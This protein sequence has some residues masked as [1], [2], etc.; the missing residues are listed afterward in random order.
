MLHSALSM[1]EY[2]IQA[3]DGDIGYAVNFYFDDR[4][5]FVRFVVCDGT[6]AFGRK[7]LIPPRAFDGKPDNCARVVKLCA[8]KGTIKNS[9]PVNTDKPVSR[10]QQ[11]ILD[12][13]YNW[14]LQPP[15]SEQALFGEPFLEANV[16]SAREILGY[17]LNDRDGHTST[18]RDFIIDDD[19]WAVD[20]LVLET[21]IWLPG[22]KYLLDPHWVEQIDWARRAMRCQV[23][24]DKI[25]NSPDYDPTAVI[26]PREE[27]IVQEHFGP[28]QYS[29]QKALEEIIR[30][31][32]QE[33]Y[34]QRGAKP[35]NDWA[36]WFEA[37]RQVKDELNRL[38]R[39]KAQE[40]CARRGCQP[41][42]ELN[43]WFEAERIVQK[44]IRKRKMQ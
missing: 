1:K 34:A 33:L 32:A 4:E 10:A 31:K 17:E 7:A 27:R 38:I 12:R 14:H 2:T 15:E 28:P 25:K 35:G 18:I 24:S 3:Q 40:L 16:H 11:H 9:P 22:K 29:T 44:Q 8:T 41:G 13:Y 30:R 6:R 37:E 36:D 20:Y 21:G 39:E 26:T 19:E 42:N 23:P 43:D 5:W